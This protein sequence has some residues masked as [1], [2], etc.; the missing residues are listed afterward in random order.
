MCSTQLERSFLG[1]K[2]KNARLLIVGLAP[3][4]HGANR[5]GRPFTGDHAG[6][7]LYA[8]LHKFGLAS[9][10]TS[11]AADDAAGMFLR[12]PAQ[13]DRRL[14]GLTEHARRP[15]VSAG[16]PGDDRDQRRFPGAI[17]TEQAEEFALLDHE[18]DAGERLHRSEAARDIDD[19][20]RGAH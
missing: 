3:G 18:I 13:F 9:R 15:A 4:K 5:T 19:F 8:T 7:L 2:M 1:T 11:T 10:G 14:A 17:R 12:F 20:D 6:I 16:E